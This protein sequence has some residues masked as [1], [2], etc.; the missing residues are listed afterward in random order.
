[1]VFDFDTERTAFHP[2]A[3]NPTLFEWT[4]KNI[5]NY[6]L[7]PDAWKRAITN[8]PVFGLGEVFAHPLNARVDH[9]FADQ[10]LTLPPG[11]TWRNLTANVFQVV[12]G[13]RIL[14]ENQDSL[15]HQLRALEPKLVALREN[16]ASAMEP[17]E[18]HADVLALFHKLEAAA[19]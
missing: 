5:E 12:D 3:N 9:F 6:L 1:M 2:E 16:V 10:N 19:G 4:R 7:V 17:E 18:I 15:F 14:F 11:R 8:D 13:K